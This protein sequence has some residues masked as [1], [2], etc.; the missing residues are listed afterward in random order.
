M[1]NENLIIK[2]NSNTNGDI[3]SKYM[4]IDPNK[5]GYVVAIALASMYMMTGNKLDYVIINNVK[6]DRSAFCFS[7][8][9]NKFNSS[10]FLRYALAAIYKDE[11]SKEELA[12]IME[13]GANH[14]NELL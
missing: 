14:L 3:L 6:M 4:I 9:K 13:K 7:S 11:L 2:I 1:S 8:N 10:K 12:V 5:E